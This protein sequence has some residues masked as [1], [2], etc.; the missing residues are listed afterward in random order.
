MILVAKCRF[1]YSCRYHGRSV[2]SFGLMKKLE[3]KEYKLICP[4]VEAL[5]GIPRLPIRKRGNRY[6]MG[7][8]DITERFVSTCRAMAQENSK[9][10]YFIGV[11]GS[12][13]CDAKVGVFAKEL[14]K[15]WVKTRMSCK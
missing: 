12:P 13:S 5:F 2:P 6:F 3:G 10:E 14:A 15:H 4:E 7:K 1:G 11:N 8:E 9:V